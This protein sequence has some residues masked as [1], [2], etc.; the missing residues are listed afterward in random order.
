METD[1]ANQARGDGGVVPPVPGRGWVDRLGYAWLAM[2]VEAYRLVIR[3]LG[4]ALMY[5]CVLWWPYVPV[6]LTARSYAPERTS[7]VI[8][9]FEWASHGPML[10]YLWLGL[11]LVS[12]ALLVWGRWV[13]PA[14]LYSLLLASSLFVTG[15]PHTGSY[16]PILCLLLVWL[17]LI[18]SRP[19]SDGYLC[20]LPVFGLIFQLGLI[21]FTGALHKLYDVWWITGDAIRIDLLVLTWTSPL[22]L[23]FVQNT[24]PG[25]MRAMTYGAL[26]LELLALPAMLCPWKT[27][28]FRRVTFAGLFALHLGSA[29]LMSLGAFPFV[30]IAYIACL[31]DRDL[32]RRLKEKSTIARYVLD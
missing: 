25:V 22:G 32:L 10:S 7:G 15:F 29:F 23:F 5:L 9:L 28:F 18:P 31:L 24:P 2:P 11:G 1:A 3:L 21:Y 12:G 8:S 6:I 30:M 19:R 27:T 4:L 16:L 13:K 14:L 17:L 20:G 26:V